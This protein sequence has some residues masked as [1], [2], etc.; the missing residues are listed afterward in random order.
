MTE[1]TRTR[2]ASSVGGL[3]ASSKSEVAPVGPRPVGHLQVVADV[4]PLPARVTAPFAPLIRWKL[5]VVIYG[6]LLG[7]AGTS[8]YVLTATGLLDGVLRALG[9][10]ALLCALAWLGYAGASVHT[11]HC[12]GCR[13]H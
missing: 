7:V 9:G 5:P 13:W 11:H 3:A 12:P 6:A 10:L 2:P 8:G 1:R 4:R